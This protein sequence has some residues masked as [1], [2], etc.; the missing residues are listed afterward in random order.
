MVNP[1]RGAF[2]VIQRFV[3]ASDGRLYSVTHSFIVKQGDNDDGDNGDD[4]LDDSHVELL[5]S[6]VC[7]PKSILETEVLS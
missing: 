7:S 3:K 5:E 2:P 4:W 6:T 1:I